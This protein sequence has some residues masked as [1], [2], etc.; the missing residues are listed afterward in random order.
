MRNYSNSLPQ[1]SISGQDCFNC[2]RIFARS[3]SRYPL[4]TIITYALFGLPLPTLFDTLRKTWDSY[5]SRTNIY[6]FSTPAR[7]ASFSTI[8]G[9]SLKFMIFDDNIV[10]NYEVY[11][12]RTAANR[13]HMQSLK[14]VKEVFLLKNCA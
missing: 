10:C 14:K 7:T 2:K 9:G 12:F 13:Y 3:S 5:V 8:S 11:E 4:P 1:I 6:L